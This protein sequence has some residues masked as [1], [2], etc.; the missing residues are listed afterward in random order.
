[1]RRVSRLGRSMW[2]VASGLAIG[3]TSGLVDVAIDYM[4]KRQDG[5]AKGHLRARIPHHLLDALTHSGLIAVNHTFRARG[6]GVTKWAFV[7]PQKGV[8]LEISALIAEAALLVVS[9]VTMQL[10]HRTDGLLFTFE[11]RE[12]SGRHPS[13]SFLVPKGTPGA[14]VSL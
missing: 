2:L 3:F 8:S 9:V 14:N 6:L 10:N 4:K 7:E 1:M 5:M 11:S 12:Q 13:P